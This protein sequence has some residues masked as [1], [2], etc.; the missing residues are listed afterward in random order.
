[1][2]N[3]L[4]KI[5][6][7]SLNT[8]YTK[9]YINIIQ[10][11]LDRNLNKKKKELK[12]LYGYVEQ[13]HIFPKSFNIDDVNNKDNLVFLLPKEHF[14]VHLCLSKMFTGD[15]KNKMIYAFFILKSNNKHQENRYYSSRLYSL[16][17]KN[18]FEKNQF[19]R[20]YLKDKVKYISKYNEDEIKSFIKNGWS[21][22][23]TDEYKE[24]RVGNMRGKKHSE[25]S[26]KKISKAHKKISKPWLMNKSKEDLDKM[27]ENMKKT[28]E[29]NKTIDPNFYKKGIEEGI[30]K[31]KKLVEDGLLSFKGNKNPRYGV[32]VDDVTKMKIKEKQERHHN[33]GLTHLELYDLYIKKYI[34]DN[35]SYEEISKLLT[36]VKRTPRKIREICN[37]FRKKL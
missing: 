31:R 35:K 32:I 23:M 15:F 10:K 5:K 7:I 28:R 37:K 16:I 30:I 26:K 21:T 27:V 17:K 8:K 6:T 2:N 11:A 4:E 25:D 18:H 33:N 34:E 3:Y 36:F 20:L 14:I 12:E 19:V 29:K 22:T 1:M 24:G 13:H 9:W